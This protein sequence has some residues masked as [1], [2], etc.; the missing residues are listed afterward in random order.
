MC[1][2]HAGPRPST[3]AGLTSFALA[4]LLA[5]CTAGINNPAVSYAV[6]R[7]TTQHAGAIEELSALVGGEKSFEGRLLTGAQRQ[8]TFAPGPKDDRQ[9]H[10]L[11]RESG[12]RRI[13]L[14]PPVPVGVDYRIEVTLM[15]GHVVRFRHCQ[16]PCELSTQ[17]WLHGTS[18]PNE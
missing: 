9:L 18:M 15:D 3:F 6:H 11:F 5:A 8:G 1:P 2:S 14:G 7:E 17:P 4:G 13:W 12:R 16:L 10:L